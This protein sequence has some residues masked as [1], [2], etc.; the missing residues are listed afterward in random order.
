MPSG[1]FKIRKKFVIKD[2]EDDLN[3]PK[4]I[5]LQ[6]VNPIASENVRDCV[7]NMTQ[8]LKF[9]WTLQYWYV[10]PKKSTVFYRGKEIEIIEN[11]ELYDVMNIFNEY[12]TIR[13]LMVLLSKHIPFVEREIKRIKTDLKK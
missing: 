11:A 1:I 5:I 2:Y 10:L 3:P 12:N 7:F 13:V 8:E 6:P 4:N 9:V